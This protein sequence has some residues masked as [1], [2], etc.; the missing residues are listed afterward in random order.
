M[1]LL[2]KLRKKLRE[3]TGETPRQGIVLGEITEPAK[4]FKNESWKKN[5]KRILEAWRDESSEELQ[6][7]FEQVCKLTP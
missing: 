1:K 3:N 6:D 7:E 4:S 5:Q 2:K